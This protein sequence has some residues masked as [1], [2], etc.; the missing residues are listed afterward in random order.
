MQ[1]SDVYM[2]V[3]EQDYVHKS[4]HVCVCELF[5]SNLFFQVAYGPA[6]TFLLW[7]LV[8][9]VYGWRVF[10]ARTANYVHP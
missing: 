2:R 1:V 7:S 9:I 3:C 6:K 8:L 5:V 10:E 4:H